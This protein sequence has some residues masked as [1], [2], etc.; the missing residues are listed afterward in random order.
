VEHEIKK[1]LSAQI[2]FPA[3]FVKTFSEVRAGDSLICEQA[4]KTHE[5][6]YVADVQQDNAYPGLMRRFRWPVSLN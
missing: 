2:N 5:S 3:S 4:M 6:I 1:A